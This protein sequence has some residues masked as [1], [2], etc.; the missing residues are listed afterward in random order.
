MALVKGMYL[1]KSSLTCPGHLIL[2]ANFL[3]GV[4]FDRDKIRREFPDVDTEI[5]VDTI[6]R[7]VPRESYNYSAAGDID[8]RLTM[9]LVFNAGDDEDYLRKTLKIPDDDTFRQ[10]VHYFMK[11]GVWPT[12]E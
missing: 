8:G 12:H 5:C 9:V 10:A 3:Q 6:L 2:S 4:I 11:A 1:F 7:N